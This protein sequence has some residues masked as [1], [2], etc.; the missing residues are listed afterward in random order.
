MRANRRP[1]TPRTLAACVTACLVMVLALPTGSAARLSRA[2]ARIAST[3]CVPISRGEPCL[4]PI[5]SVYDYP[6]LGSGAVTY[7]H[8][9][10]GPVTEIG[11]NAE[12]EPITERTFTWHSIPS[13]K[14]VAVFVVTGVGITGK[15]HYQRVP[16]GEHSGHATLTG[17]Y[18]RNPTL[19]LEGERIASAARASAARCVSYVREARCLGPIQVLYPM[20]GRDGGALRSIPAKLGP[21]EQFGTE[22]NGDPI[23]HRTLSWH[24]AAGVKLVVAY[25]LTPTIQ[26]GKAGF[27]FHR[28][29][30]GA[31]SGRIV[32][33]G[34][35]QTTTNDPEREPMVLL[36]GER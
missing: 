23:I 14:I 3:R 18:R 20:F 16:T 19:L 34:T 22:P 36:E 31:Y 33:T 32:L 11:K 25:E 24:A 29:P 21:E 7:I 10:A 30:T 8:A 15:Y 26:H 6:G 13:V 28:V 5:Q 17:G 27:H 9:K 2:T 35:R 4:A 1:T 12:D